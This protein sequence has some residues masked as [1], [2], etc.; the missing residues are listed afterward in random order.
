MIGIIIGNTAM[1]AC[2][3]LFSGVVLAMARFTACAA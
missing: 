2:H 3:T 1:F